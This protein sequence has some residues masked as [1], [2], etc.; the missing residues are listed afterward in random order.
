MAEQLLLVNPRRRRVGRPRKRKTPT[1]RRRR[2]NPRQSYVSGSAPARNPRRRRRRPVTKRRYRR[3]PRR[4]LRVANIFQETVMPAVTAAGGALGL[5]ILW[6]ML[7]I[8]I[9]MKTGPIR[10]LAKGAGAIAM[11]FIA[12]FVVPTQTAKHFTSGA[13]TVV[14]YDALKEMVAVWMPQLALAAYD[15]EEGVSYG[16]GAYPGAA[17]DVGDESMLSHYGEGEGMSAYFNQDMEGLGA[18]LTEDEP[19]VFI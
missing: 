4:G 16:V 12:S 3:N 1:R 7:P 9:T 17:L 5:D 10:Y 19:E 11:G 13:M 14:M 2:R 8:P 18:Y 15:I 6:G